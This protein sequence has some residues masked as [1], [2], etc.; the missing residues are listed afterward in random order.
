[1]DW[2]GEGKPVESTVAERRA[3]VCAD[4][5]M[6]DRKAKNILES[7]TVAAAKEIMAIFSALNDLN[8]HTS[9]DNKLKVCQA[10][11]CP[12]KAKVWA[13]LHII[14]KHLSEE[15]FDRLH[16]SCWIRHE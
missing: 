14:K 10:C 13:P 2:F 4:C 16:A 1:M 15:R 8:L 9:Q 11:D 7:F 5:P 6:N 3:A 12:L